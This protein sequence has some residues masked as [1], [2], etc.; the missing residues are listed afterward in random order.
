MET[1]RTFMKNKQPTNKNLQQIVSLTHLPQRLK[2]AQTVRVVLH[3]VLNH[4][5]DKTGKRISLISQWG[6]PACFFKSLT[7][8]FQTKICDYLCISYKCDINHKCNTDHKKKQLLSTLK[9]KINPVTI[10]VIKFDHECNKLNNHKYNT[11]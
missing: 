1:Q 6:W 2:R 10:D 11:T 7:S 9:R 3:I 5:G 8:V 4:Q